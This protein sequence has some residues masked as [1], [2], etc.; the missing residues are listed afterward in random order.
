A[1]KAPPMPTSWQGVPRSQSGAAPARIEPTD[2]AITASARVE[3]A[4]S[5]AGPRLRA[6]LEQVCVRGSSLQ[7]A[8]QALSLRRRQ[9]KTVLKQGLQALAAHYGYG[10]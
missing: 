1:E 7:L 5:A 9:G 4:L 3:A 10:T 6:M 2:R 8:E